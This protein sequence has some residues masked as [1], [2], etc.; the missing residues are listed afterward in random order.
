LIS[1]FSLA[2]LGAITTTYTAY[3]VLLV[4]LSYYFLS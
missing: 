4:F 3:K 1:L 2:V